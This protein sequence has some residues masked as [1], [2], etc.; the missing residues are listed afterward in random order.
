MM[1]LYE[2]DLYAKALRYDQLVKAIFDNSTLYGDDTLVIDSYR[3]D[4]IL[5][6]IISDY[7]ARIKEVRK[8]E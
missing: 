7:D 2:A 1:E 4:G 5:K 6:V 8:G 3:L